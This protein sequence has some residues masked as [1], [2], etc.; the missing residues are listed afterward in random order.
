[1]DGRFEWAL[2]LAAAPKHPTTAQHKHS[3]VP[4]GH[5]PHPWR[6]SL[7]SPYKVSHIRSTLSLLRSA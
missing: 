4:G 5:S 2:P 7:R 1:M 3:S 6:G